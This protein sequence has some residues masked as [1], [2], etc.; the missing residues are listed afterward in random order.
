M[1]K[2]ILFLLLVSTLCIDSALCQTDYFEVLNKI[3]IDI[4]KDKVSF[5]EMVF[6]V[7][8][9]YNDGSINRAN[10]DSDISYLVQLI[11]ENQSLNLLKYEGKDKVVIS[12][13]AAIFKT[14][15]LDSVSFLI[16]DSK[17]YLQVLPFKYDF[18]DVFGE[19]RYE[20]LLK[21]IGSHLTRNHLAVEDAHLKTTTKG[22][23]FADAIAADLFV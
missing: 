11:K 9:T 5:K 23:L 21:N 19:N 17:K 14:M 20:C 3:Q 12:K 4:K 10:F 18:D 7:E 8:N 6:L 15:A 13:Y 16:K 22:K 1:K 2:Y